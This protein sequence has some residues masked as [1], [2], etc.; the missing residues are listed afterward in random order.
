MSALMISFFFGLG[1]SG[2]VY[3]KLARANGNG[4]SKQ[5]M[6]AAVIAGALAFIVIFTLC[7]YIF[8]FD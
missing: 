2:F 6:I 3:A 8:N 4:D 1:L 7:K 5:N